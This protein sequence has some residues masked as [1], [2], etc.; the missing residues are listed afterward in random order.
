MEPREKIDFILEQI[1]LILDKQ[2][3]VRAFIVSKKITTKA[4]NN[5]NHQVL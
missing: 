2:D 3:Y 5:E 1:R 4:L